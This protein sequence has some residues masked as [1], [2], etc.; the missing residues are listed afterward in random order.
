MTVTGDGR[1][2]ERAWTRTRTSLVYNGSLQS[3]ARQHRRAVPLSRLLQALQSTQSH[4]DE[5]N[6]AGCVLV[7]QQWQLSVSCEVG[8][9]SL[10][11]IRCA[12]LGDAL[13]EATLEAVV[14][15]RLLEHLLQGRHEVHLLSARPGK[16]GHGARSRSVNAMPTFRSRERVSSHCA[17]GGRRENAP[18]LCSFSHDEVRPRLER[19]DGV[20]CKPADCVAG[21][22]SHTSAHEC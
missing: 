22:E 1:E 16:R 11:R 4:T 18:F 20:C 10:Q 3:V 9:T 2:G 12:R 7:S 13:V 19:D 17:E 21:G 6:A 15:A 8:R 14:D 5:T